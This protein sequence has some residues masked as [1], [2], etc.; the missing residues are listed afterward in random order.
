[1]NWI[2]FFFFLLLLSLKWLSSLF[3]NTSELVSWSSS[4]SFIT[5]LFFITVLSILYYIFSDIVSSF[6]ASSYS[7]NL[8]LLIDWFHSNKFLNLFN[9]YFLKNIPKIIQ[10]I[11]L[12]NKRSPIIEY[13]SICQKELSLFC[14]EIK[15]I[16]PVVRQISEKMISLIYF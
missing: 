7:I 14:Y 8:H 2:T 1:M 11:I 16:V 5:L 6:L 3:L 15:N 10:K 12:R 4:S 13:P 9:L